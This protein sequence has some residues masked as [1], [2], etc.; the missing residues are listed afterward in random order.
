LRIVSDALLVNVALLFALALRFSYLVAFELEAEISRRQL[1][2]NYARAYRNTA[3]LL[4]VIC[5]AVFYLSGFYTYGRAYRGRYKALIVAQAVSLSYL[6]FGFLTY[7]ITDVQL[8]RGAL[9]LAWVTTM[10]LLMLARLWSLLWRNVLLAEHQLMEQTKPEE[11]KSV[12]VIGGAGYIGSALLPKLLANG[13]KVRLLDLLLYGSAPISEVE[14]H[15][16][17]EIVNADFRH[18]DKV[19]EAMRGVDAVI[20]LGAIVGDP[21]CELDSELTIEINLMAT[22]MIAEVAKGSGVQRFLFA[23]T[24]SVY[25]VSDEVLDECSYLRPVSLYAKSKIASEKV[26]MAMGDHRFAPTIL[27]FGTIYGLSGRTRF[28]LVVNLLAAKAVTDGKITICGGAQ[29]RPFL[30]VDD[31]ALSVLTVLEAPISLVGNEVFNVGSD[32][33]NYRIEEVG[34][35]IRQAVPGSQI[36]S[37]EAGDDARD[38]R[39]S[40][41]KIRQVL[42]FEPRWQL[43][44]GIEQVVN[45]VR[46][47]TVRDYR[48]PI[49]SNVRFL[50]E[51]G[52]VSLIPRGNQWAH[53]LIN[54]GAVV[55]T[56]LKEA[57]SGQAP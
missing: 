37:F 26:L 51:H 10:A 55:Q 14:N 23:S 3:G 34:E 21:A 13:Y 11:I 46:N 18:V 32:R 20:H 22:R 15:P 52:I 47:G 30:H 4:T 54:Q 28:D 9:V 40:F 2:W 53:E 27:R 57:V 41:N 39:V 38:Y 45:I 29:W 49:H 35:L 36:V 50:N 7:F 56:E 6:L 16:N 44:Q 25:G 24:C 33:Q 42:D 1:F 12:L 48:D 19:V 8:P 5:L 17:L 43:E 31:A